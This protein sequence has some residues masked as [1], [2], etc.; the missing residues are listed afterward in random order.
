MRKSSIFNKFMIKLWLVTES[1]NQPIKTNFYSGPTGT[2]CKRIRIMKYAVNQIFRYFPHPIH[3]H[4]TNAEVRRVTGC[5]AASRLVHIRRLQPFSHLAKRPDEEDHRRVLVAAM[6][7]WPTGWRRPRG[8]PGG[9]WLRTVSKRY[10]ALQ[11]R[12]P[13]GLASCC[14]SSAVAWTVRHCCAPAG[15]SINQ[16][17]NQWIFISDRSHFEDH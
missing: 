13:L 12:H 14:R 11:H 10:S 15:V 1:I 8:C 17:I 9:T 4:V 7:N 6:S 2:C 3:R 16:S 5:L